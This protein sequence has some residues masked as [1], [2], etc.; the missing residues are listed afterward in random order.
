MV[1][2]VTTFE[3]TDGKKFTSEVEANGHEK[4]LSIG[5][6]IDA[7]TKAAGVG[8]AEATR[9]RKYISGYAAFMETYDGPL[10]HPP[11]AEAANDATTGPG[12]EGGGEPAGEQNDDEQQAA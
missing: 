12:A 5:A 7:Y 11:K 1:K 3:T 10:A 2:Q 8:P 6:A 9:A 4:A